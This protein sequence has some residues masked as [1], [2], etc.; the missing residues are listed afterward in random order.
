MFVL[1]RRTN[2]QIRFSSVSHEGQVKQNLPVD[3]QSP[4]D[5]HAARIFGPS[6]NGFN[7]STAQRITIFAMSCNGYDPETYK[8][9]PETNS[10]GEQNAPSNRK[11]FNWKDESQCLL[12]IKYFCPV[13]KELFMLGAVY[14]RY[15]ERVDS[16]IPWVVRRQAKLVAQGL[17]AQL[18]EQFSWACWEEFN[19]REIKEINLAESRDMH[20]R[21]DS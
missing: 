14:N 20:Q 9:V 1:R 7:D 16:V 19:E 6:T 12:V 3:S 13:K 2:R 18:P 8:W 4:A 15:E 11:I 5:Q 17:V 21:Q 10:V